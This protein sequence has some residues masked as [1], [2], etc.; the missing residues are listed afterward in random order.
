[1]RRPKVV[2][3]IPDC[4]VKVSGLTSHTLKYLNPARYPA[5]LAR[6]YRTKPM[7]MSCHSGKARSDLRAWPSSIWGRQILMQLADCRTHRFSPYFDRPLVWAGWIEMNCRC[8]EPTHSPHLHHP[9]SSDLFI[10]RYFPTF[11]QPNDIPLQVYTPLCLSN[12]MNMHTLQMRC[13]DHLGIFKTSTSFFP[14]Q[15]NS[16]SHK[17]FLWKTRNCAIYLMNSDEATESRLPTCNLFHL[18]LLSQHGMVLG[19]IDLCIIWGI[20]STYFGR[21]HQQPRQ[22]NIAQVKCQTWTY[23]VHCSL[24]SDVPF[25][26]RPHTVGVSPEKKNPT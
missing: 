20:I 10:S 18:P 24:L 26:V 16:I 14:I 3:S 9:S 17:I 2:R 1:M 8:C 19:T 6:F 15:F 11:L 5:P 13:L 22:L 25:W 23:L 4:G 7:K 21:L 12:T